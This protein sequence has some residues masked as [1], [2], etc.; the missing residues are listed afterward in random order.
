PTQNWSLPSVRP[1]RQELAPAA[2]KFQRHRTARVSCSKAPHVPLN[3]SEIYP[4]QRFNKRSREMRPKDQK[5][6]K[7]RLGSAHV[8]LEFFCIHIH[9]LETMS[10]R[11]RL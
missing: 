5:A 10:A 3:K 11:L 8:P 1:G 2:N 4:A 9:A 6:V 7:N